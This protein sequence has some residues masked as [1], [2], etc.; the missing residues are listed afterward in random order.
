MGLVHHFRRI[1]RDGRFYAAI[2]IAAV[3]VFKISIVA[4]LRRIQI[5]VPAQ[6]RVVFKDHLAFGGATVIVVR[7]SVVTFLIAFNG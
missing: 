6:G 1:V 4:G 7:I 3:T 5:S 2:G